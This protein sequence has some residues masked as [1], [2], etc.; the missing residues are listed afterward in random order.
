MLVATHPDPLRGN[1]WRAHK[2]AEEEAMLGCQ[3]DLQTAWGGG[4]LL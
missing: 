3:D 2:P 4:D 1:R